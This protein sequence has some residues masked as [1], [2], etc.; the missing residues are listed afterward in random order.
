[1][2]GL[3]PKRPIIF[4]KQSIYE[5]TKLILKEM[6]QPVMRNEENIRKYVK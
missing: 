2:Y 6:N 4:L 1:M 3:F 5:T